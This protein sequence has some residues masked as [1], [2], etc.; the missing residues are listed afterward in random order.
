MK[1]L[2][3]LNYRLNT[4]KNF[5]E[6]YPQFNMNDKK[7]HVLFLSPC[8]NEA[9][10]YR[11]ILPALELN[12]TDTHSAIIGHIHKWDFNKLF[13]DYDTPI[14]FRLV[15]WADYVVLPVMFTDATYIIKSM[16]EINDDIE[17]VM[18]MEVN[19]H[20]LPEYHPD[21]KKLQPE[22]K[23]M[24]VSNLSKVDILSAPNNQ[25]L[26]YY[27][28][29]VQKHDEEFLLY[30][31]RF[32]NLLSNFTFE[33]ITQIQ[34]NSTDKVRVGIVLDASQGNDLKTIEKPITALLEKHKDK[35]EIIIFGWS[36]KIAEQYGLL[37]ELRITYEKPVPFQEHHQRLNSLAFDIALLP[38][39]DNTY[40][41]SGRSLNRYLDFSANMIPAIVPNSFPFT[42]IVKEA[43]NGFIAASDEDWINKTD[44]LITNAQLRKDIGN[45]AFKTSWEGFSY[46]PKAIQR[47]KSIFI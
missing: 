7:I 24:L 6:K 33:E 42:N 30:F 47:L 10:Y 46:T 37:N 8:M 40:N 17:F 39:A 29:L 36:K 22:L 4:V 32:P 23:K 31:E 14:D 28:D 41:A 44:Q 5:K 9:G 12:R 27:N 43:E 34:R 15:E 21:F 20:E 13:D 25:I 38:L 1:T 16:R 19:Y 11:M 2:K 26:N 45:N 35:I 18:D 3:E